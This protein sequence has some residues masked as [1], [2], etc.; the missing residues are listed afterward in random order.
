MYLVQWR[1]VESISYTRITFIVAADRTL[2][3]FSTPVGPKTFPDVR[4]S[5]LTADV[6][7]DVS[8]F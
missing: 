2:T 3:I 1:A 5:D 4:E 6:S 8:N 7:S